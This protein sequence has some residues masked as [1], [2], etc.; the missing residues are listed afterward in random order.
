[1]G[2]AEIERAQA[3][4]DVMRS[5]YKPMATIRAG[6][7]STMAEGPGAMLMIGVSVP[8]W[9]ESLSAGVAEARSMERMARADF[10]AMKLMVAGEVAVAREDVQAARETVRSLE[11]EI[12]PRASTAVDAALAAYSAGQ[13][14]LVSVIDASGAAW[15]ARGDLVMANSVLGQASVSLERALGR[16]PST[17]GGR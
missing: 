15:R 3:E 7:A 9:R 16:N 13:G 6:R 8:I 12:I 11:V 10:E 1:M 17:E 14:S 5:M 4:I 2:E